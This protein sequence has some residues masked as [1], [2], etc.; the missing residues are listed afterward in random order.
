[1]MDKRTS[2]LSPLIILAVIALILQIAVA[3]NIA[4]FTIVPNIVLVVVCLVSLT[5]S[6]M[7]AVIY[8][9]ILG[10]CYDVLS[11]GPIGVMA[12]LF[13]IIGFV[14]STIKK[15][16][17]DSNWLM[18]LFVLL[19]VIFLGEILHGIIL[20]VVGYDTDIMSSLVFRA[21][22]AALY[23]AVITTIV[24]FVMNRFGGSGSHGRSGRQ[25]SQ[26]M[27]QTRGRPSSQGRPLNRKLR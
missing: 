4:I 3:P 14:L 27:F 21:L 8:S 7:R 15:D 2:R 19:I 1:M 23:E 10:F 12:L 16:S 13:T 5:A 17:L 25:K 9:F 20:A 6:T 18:D 22:P 11:Q 24:L 26:N